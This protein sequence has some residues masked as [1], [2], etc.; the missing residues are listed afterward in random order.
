MNSIDLSSRCRLPEVM[1]SPDLDPARHRRALTALRRINRLS[2]AAAQLLAEL[3]PL[4]RATRGR[5]LRVLDL[6]CGGGDVAIEL[7]ALASRQG[8]SVEVSAC[9][10]SVTA[11]GHAREAA[12]RAGS[13][14]RFFRWDLESEPVPPGHDVVCC[15][16]FLHHLDEDEALA[17]L[18]GMASAAQLVIVQDLLR[19]RL[20]WWLSHLASRFL[21]TSSVVR[22]DAPLSVRAALSLSEA[23]ELAERS[24]L[25]GA[26]LRR[27]W[28]ERFS[29]SWRSPS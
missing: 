20:G 26:N 11:L 5:P 24:G 3:E 19:T 8:L 28:P 17:L 12:H 9:D 16:L 10:V 21:T 18:R 14:V 15:T 4:A 13:P 2:N 7:E 22:V 27:I 1:D 29:L 25:G 23:R 6:A